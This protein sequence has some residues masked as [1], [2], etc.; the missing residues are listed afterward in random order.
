MV[1]EF[2]G[3]EE[4]ESDGREGWHRE[5]RLKFKEGRGERKG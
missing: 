4:F 5:E 2:Y 3:F 1:V